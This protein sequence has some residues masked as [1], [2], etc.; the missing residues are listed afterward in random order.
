[1]EK[2]DLRRPYL[3]LQTSTKLVSSCALTVTATSMSVAI[4]IPAIVT[5]ARKPHALFGPPQPL[6][7]HLSLPLRAKS[8]TFTPLGP[9]HV[10]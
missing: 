3:P 7:P 8:I 4:V 1:M 10:M 6:P 2:P 9:L 5:R